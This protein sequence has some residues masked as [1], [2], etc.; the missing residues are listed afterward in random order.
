MR[1]SRWD[2]KS[3][4]KKP[5]DQLPSHSSVSKYNNKHISDYSS[6][7]KDHASNSRRDSRDD[8][9]DRYSSRKYS[10]NDYDAKYLKKSSRSRSRDR[11]SSHNRNRKYSRSRSRS[12]S[13]D[14][15]SYQDHKNSEY[16][17][18]RAQ[19][20]ATLSKHKDGLQLVKEDA[21]VSNEYKPGMIKIKN[22]WVYPEDEV[23]SNEGTWEHKKRLEEMEK[24]KSNTFPLK[25]LCALPYFSYYLKPLSNKLSFFYISLFFF[26]KIHQ[27]DALKS[28]EMAKGSHHIAHFL[29]KDQLEEFN[30]RI[31]QIKNSS[32]PTQS[33]NNL[34][35]SNNIGFQ[36]LQKQGWSS[37]QGLG[38]G[39]QGITAPITATQSD[40]Q[41]SG[42]GQKPTHEISA[43]DDEFDL[44][45]K[46]MMLAYKYRPN[47]LNNPRRQYY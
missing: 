37:G 12:R 18:H 36:L 13:R 42:L 41:S 15:V 46:K 20:K 24:T 3:H 32:K 23:V 11:G 8:F 7:Y 34:I 39:A 30:K 47:P 9:E 14:R 28:T 16:R 17:S 29:P 25:L 44:Y 27:G 10:R 2:Q 26:L 33:N 38:L 22:K 6:Q 31:S 5:E 1:K 19:R 21:L 35:D 45:R 40:T 43:E 4:D